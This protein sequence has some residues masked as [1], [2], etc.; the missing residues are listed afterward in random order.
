MFTCFLIAAIITT[1]IFV[2]IY[3]LCIHYINPKIEQKQKKFLEKKYQFDD[4]KEINSLSIITVSRENS[5]DE[6]FQPFD[7]EPNKEKIN[8]VTNFNDIEI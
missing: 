6:I 4:Q 7:I 2:L 3:L 8:K 5:S 1:P